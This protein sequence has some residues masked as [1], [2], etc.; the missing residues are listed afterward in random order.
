MNCAIIPDCDG[1]RQKE[2]PKE[3][4]E[5]AAGADVL[6]L[7]GLRPNP[8]PSHMTIGEAVETAA[9]IGARQSLLTHMT[10]SVDYETMEASL[11]ETIRLAYDGLRVNL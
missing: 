11:P 10:Y 3:A 6:V 8:H 9:V 7:D 1:K 4:R 2:V 5:L